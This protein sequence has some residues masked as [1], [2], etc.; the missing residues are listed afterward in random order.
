[1]VSNLEL[2]DLFQAISTSLRRLISHD[3]AALLL[4]DSQSSDMLR[5]YALDFPEGRG[6][7]HQDMLLPMHGSNPGKAFRHGQPM[8][9]GS[10]PGSVPFTSERHADDRQGRAALQ[11]D[12]PL[13]LNGKA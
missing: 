13:V 6:F 8:L 1:M 10:G 4:P 2:R 11:H 9:V 12:V 3:S 7:V 5:I